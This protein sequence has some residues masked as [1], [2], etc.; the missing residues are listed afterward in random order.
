MIYRM[1]ALNI[2]GTLLNNGRLNKDT[3]EAIDYVQ[4]KGI[5]VTLITGRTFPSAKRVAKALKIDNPLVTHQG[6]YIGKQMGKPLYVNKIHEDITYELVKFLEE[7]NC[8]LRVVQDK[9][10]IMNRI[11]LTGSLREKV[12]YNRESSFIYSTHYTDSLSEYLF[13]DPSSALKIEAKFNSESEMS[14]AIK[15]IKGMYH[16]VDCIVTGAGRMDIVKRGVS[17]LRGLLYVC[18]RAGITRDQV[19]M[20][21]ANHDDKDLLDCCGLGIAMGNAPLEVKHAA[22]WITRSDKQNGVAY[23]VKELFRKQQPIEFLRKMNVIKS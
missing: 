18:E 10:A 19:V 1:L 13:E 15:A 23:A 11:K 17:K 4:S 20:V 6:A 21:G 8:Q 14:D 7:L 2:D 22:D 3:K 16:E 12:L 9:M 5:H